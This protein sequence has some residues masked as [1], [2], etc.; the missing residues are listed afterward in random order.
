[1]EQFAEQV[2]TLLAS[3][4]YLAL[5]TGILLL[6][7]RLLPGVGPLCDRIELAFARF[8]TFV[9][10]I[11]TEWRRLLQANLPGNRI[12]RTLDPRGDQGDPPSTRPD[13]RD[14]ALDDAA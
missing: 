5:A 1:M 6:I 10:R 4:P 12:E 2:Q 3:H 14:D 8:V 11:R 13:V 9:I 7:Y